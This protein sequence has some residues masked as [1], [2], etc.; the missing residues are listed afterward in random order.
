ML[1][2]FVVCYVCVVNGSQKKVAPEVEFI[3][4]NCQTI[5]S[6]NHAF[7]EWHVENL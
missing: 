5:V 1:F 4:L 3:D 2:R 6:G 7:T